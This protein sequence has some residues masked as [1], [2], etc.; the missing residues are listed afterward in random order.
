MPIHAA[1]AK[2]MRGQGL[3]RATVDVVKLLV[4]SAPGTLLEGEFHMIYIYYDK[5]LS[6]S[7]IVILFILSPSEGDVDGFLPIQIVL[8]AGEVEANSNPNC[9][10]EFVRL[11]ASSEA[12]LQ[13]C[14]QNIIVQL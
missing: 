13:G 14:V 3:N 5:K 1:C 7:V 4:E 9:F 2:V 10:L 11:L 8:S 12:M 6:L